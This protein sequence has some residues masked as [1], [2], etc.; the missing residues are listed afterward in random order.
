MIN[1][2]QLIVTMTSTPSRLAN[3]FLEKTL[4]HFA[5]Q[6]RIEDVDWFGFCLDNNVKASDVKAHE[7]LFAKI[8]AETGL[9]WNLRTN[10]ADW[11]SCNKLIPF[12][13]ENP[14]RYICCI[15]S[16]KLYPHTALD[17]LL[18]ESSRNPDCIIA[19]EANPAVR[20][21]KGLVFLNSTTCMLKQKCWDCYL[22]NMCLFPPGCFDE[23]YL[24]DKSVFQWVYNSSH[25]ER[26]FWLASCMKG[27]QSISLPY[28]YSYT[29]EANR[30]GT[31]VSFEFDEGALSH[32]NGQPGVIE[33]MNQRCCERYGRKLLQKTLEKPVV[34]ELTPEQ[35]QL[36]VW[37]LPYIKR[38]Y[39]GFDVVVDMSRCAGSWRKV[40]AHTA[41]KL[42]FG[43]RFA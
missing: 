17:E 36:F 20:T 11:R 23:E 38:L 29:I 32:E 27:T 39:N 12:Y 24:F 13:A 35:V 19:E 5:R 21:D 10:D 40:L 37:S 26:A 42:G 31:P 15:D 43:M 30:D 22:S 33:R 6:T 7:E 28:T 41:M 16:D 2:K 8:E 25:D 1:G 18:T 9:K 3:G 4:R 34:F 14:D